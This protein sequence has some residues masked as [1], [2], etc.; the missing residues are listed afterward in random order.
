MKSI[1][2]LA[3]VIPAMTGQVVNGGGE[4]RFPLT[5]CDTSDGWKEYQ[6]NC[7]KLINGPVGEGR[8]YQTTQKLCAVSGV[9]H[10]QNGEPLT[11]L[12]EGINSIAD[13]HFV[14]DIVAGG[15]RAWI[16]AV[17][18]VNEFYWVRKG[19]ATTFDNWKPKEPNNKGGNENC[20]EI[21]RGPPGKWN[22]LPCTRKRAGVCQY[23]IAQYAALFG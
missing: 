6:G 10:P 13:N 8:D 2:L 20:I 17:R 12:V 14:A 18:V 5:G 3:L 19:V 1:I 9:R 11:S 16:G 7:Y 21:N 23:N 15:Q 22:D 4:L